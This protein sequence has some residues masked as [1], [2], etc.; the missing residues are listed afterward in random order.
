MDVA[1]LNISIKTSGV[2]G[3]KNDLNNL[4]GAVKKAKNS[5]DQF[6][7]SLLAVKAAA[8]A[9]AGSALIKEF[10]QT[11]DAMSNM[12]SRIKMATSSMS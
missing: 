12:N 5:A 1:N 3:A 4:D 2:S 9:I 7:G 6:R 8:A 10:V 11:A